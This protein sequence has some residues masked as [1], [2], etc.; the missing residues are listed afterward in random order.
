VFRLRF[1]RRSTPFVSLGAA[2]GKVAAA[3]DSRGRMT[4]VT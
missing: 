1:F 4:A 3:E 2:I